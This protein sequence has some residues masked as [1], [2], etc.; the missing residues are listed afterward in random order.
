MPSAKEVMHTEAIVVPPSMSVQSLAEL[1]IKENSDGACVVE[2]GKL[3]GVATAMDLVFQEKNPHIPK[4]IALLD[5]VIPLESSKRTREEI[6]KISGTWVRDI[7]SDEP[8]TIGPDTPLSDAATMMV[9]KHLTILP[10]VQDGELLGAIT[11][12]DVL[13]AAFTMD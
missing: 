3:I 1:L 12:R 11:K 13:K 7:M 5:S 6:D 9:E 8:I 2:D 10:V 4:V